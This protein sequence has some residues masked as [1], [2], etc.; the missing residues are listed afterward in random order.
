MLLLQ[1]LVRLRIPLIV[2][3][4]LT[5]NLPRYLCVWI[6]VGSPGCLP[7]LSLLR[8]RAC[9]GFPTVWTVVGHQ[10]TSIVTCRALDRNRHPVFGGEF[11]YPTLDSHSSLDGVIGC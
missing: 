2:R 9:E 8:A 3:A 7:P 11:D 4:R 1:T 5:L 6:F 10:P